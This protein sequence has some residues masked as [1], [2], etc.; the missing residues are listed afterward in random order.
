MKKNRTRRL[1]TNSQKTERRKGLE[2]R[3]RRRSFP[4]FTSSISVSNMATSHVLFITLGL[5]FFVSVTQ[6][7]TSIPYAY[8]SLVAKNTEGV[9]VQSCVVSINS[10]TGGG[11]VTTFYNSTIVGFVPSAICVDEYT[12][13][14]YRLGN[15]LTNLCDNSAPNWIEIYQNG[16]VIFLPLTGDGPAAHANF[17]RDAFYNSRVGLIYATVGI[18]TTVKISKPSPFSSSYFSHFK[19][20]QHSSQLFFRKSHFRSCYHRTH[21]W[22][23]EGFGSLPRRFTRNSIWQI[24]IQLRHF[25]C[26]HHR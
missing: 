3:T 15:N 10:T 24:G 23:F 22:C 9:V 18:I 2:I 12:G 8:G 13:T 17:Y 19:G 25:V 5:F 16:T 14:I 20:I 26:L 1:H 21:F 4:H 7:A 11:N 6:G